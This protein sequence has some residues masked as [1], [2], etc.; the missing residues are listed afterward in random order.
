MKKLLCGFFIF[1]M[2]ITFVGCTSKKEFKE[3]INVFDE[4]KDSETVSKY[5][6]KHKNYDKKNDPNK[7]MGEDNQYV[8][9]V[10]WEDNRVEAM[11]DEKYSGGTIEFYLNEKDAKIRK[12]FLEYYVEVVDRTFPEDEYGQYA[13]IMHATNKVVHQRGNVVIYLSSQLEKDEIDDYFKAFDTILEDAEFEQKK[14]PSKKEQASI[15]K[16]RKQ[17][18]DETMSEA[19]KTWDEGLNTIADAMEAEVANVESTLD[20]GKLTTT[21]SGIEEYNIPFFKDRYESW[22]TRLETSKTTIANNKKIAE[23]KAAAERAIELGNTNAKNK[24][25][26][27]LRSLPFSHSGLVKQLLYEGFTQEQATYGADNCG[28]D[29]NKQASLKAQAYL[30]SLSFSRQGL[31]NQLLYEGYTQEQAEYGVSSVGY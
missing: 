28:A 20:E 19:K 6:K 24:A 7:V 3:A 14:V 8:S 5:I 21:E 16:E 31:I 15:L 27:Y 2:C 26:S 13:T 1:T 29:W 17:S 22:K 30:R 25:L 11:P 10:S 12:D 4:L 23:E 9:R 18:V